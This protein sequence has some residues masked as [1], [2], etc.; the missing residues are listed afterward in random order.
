MQ[1]AEHIEVAPRMWDKSIAAPYIPSK[2]AKQTEDEPEVSTPM[3][4]ATTIAVA[5]SGFMLK[6]KTYLL[7]LIFILAIIIVIYV[8][9]KYFTKYRKQRAEQ[10]LLEQAQATQLIQASPPQVPSPTDAVLA[11]DTS[12]YECESESE[13]EDEEEEQPPV[14]QRRKLEPIEEIDEDDEEGTEEECKEAEEETEEEG[15]TDE[16]NE[17]EEE[18]VAMLEEEPDID[19][20]TEMLESK[21]IEDMDLELPTYE[22]D[23]QPKPKKSRRGS[24]RVGV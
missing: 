6:M 10:K 15:E 18:D 22:V 9:W 24:K 12:K 21:P 19:K 5:T 17:T 3:E 4:Q 1:Q 23:E 14:Q 8:L 11:G 7:P 16:D 13:S 20:I 2:A